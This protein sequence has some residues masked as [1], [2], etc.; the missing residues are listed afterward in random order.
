MS[1][2]FYLKKKQTNW[3]LFEFSHF[4]IFNP[5]VVIQSN[6]ARLIYRI[7]KI[8]HAGKRMKCPNE[9]ILSYNWRPSSAGR[10]KADE[11]YAMLR[12]RHEE[13]QVNYNTAQSAARKRGLTHTPTHTPSARAEFLLNLWLTV[14]RRVILLKSTS[15]A[16]DGPHLEVLIPSGWRCENKRILYYIVST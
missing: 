8:F 15:P 13:G 1:N 9:T 14:W 2:I 16:W 7:R 12:W 10:W 5:S 4:I 6:E 11:K 3:S